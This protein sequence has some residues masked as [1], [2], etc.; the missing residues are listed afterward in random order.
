MRYPVVSIRDGIR[1]PSHVSQVS[2]DRR[3]EIEE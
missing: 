3:G 2:F 1:V